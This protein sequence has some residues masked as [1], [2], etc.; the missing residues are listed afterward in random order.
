MRTFGAIFAALSLALSASAAAILPR[1][2]LADANG[3]GST[4]DYGLDGVKAGVY[5]RRVDFSQLTDALNGIA[6]STNA[7]P[8]GGITARDNNGNSF[9]A[10]VHDATVQV[11]GII[12]QLG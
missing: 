10:I 9:P 5:R 7:P 8:P 11:Q 1:D 2:G 3:A 6:P 4:T 12:A